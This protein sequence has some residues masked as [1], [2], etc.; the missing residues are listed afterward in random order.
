[1]TPSPCDGVHGAANLVFISQLK[2]CMNA[3]GASL[4]GE[5]AGYMGG[6]SPAS[7]PDGVNDEVGA[8]PVMCECSWIGTSGDCGST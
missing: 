6:G 8:N 4:A 2:G 7:G 1:V 3:Q 5:A